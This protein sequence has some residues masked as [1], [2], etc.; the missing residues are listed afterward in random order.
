MKFLQ[1]LPFVAL[2]AAQKA[3]GPSGSAMTFSQTPKATVTF[4]ISIPN[5]GGKDFIGRIVRRL[6]NG[7]CRQL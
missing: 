4:G 2:A 5:G 3:S 1:F 6:R 7:V